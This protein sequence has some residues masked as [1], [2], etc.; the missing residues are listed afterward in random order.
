MAGEL[1]IRSANGRRIRV[2]ASGR[3]KTEF[4]GVPNA[5]DNSVIAKDNK[6]ANETGIGVVILTRTIGPK[7]DGEISNLRNDGRVL[8]LI[9]MIANIGRKTR[10]EEN[11]GWWGGRWSSMRN[12]VDCGR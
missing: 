12:S 3:L 2:G 1:T 8:M 9:K 7:E 11:I 4:L 6:S 10:I 5:F